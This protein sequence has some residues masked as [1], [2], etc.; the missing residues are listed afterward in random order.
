MDDPDDFLE[1]AQDGF[2]LVARLG[3]L[4]DDESHPGVGNIKIGQHRQKKGIPLDGLLH[5]FFVIGGQ[6]F[7]I[8]VVSS[9]KAVN[10][11]H[12]HYNVVRKDKLSMFL[13][14]FILIT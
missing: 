3:I 5:D 2:F 9:Q 6:P 10:A 13:S 14:P 7:F 11:E 8:K 1:I 4:G 12:V